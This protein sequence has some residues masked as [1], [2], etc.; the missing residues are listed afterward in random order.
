MNQSKEYELEFYEKYYGGVE[1]VKKIMENCPQCS[2]KM[3]ISHVPDSLNLI[4]EEG[5]E[6][7]ACGHTSKR[8]LH[9]VC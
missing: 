5:R 9:K 8:V 2:S 6:C 1:E 4:M 3:I 7:P